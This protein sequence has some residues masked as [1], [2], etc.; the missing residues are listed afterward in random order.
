MIAKIISALITLS[1]L[2]FLITSTY[3]NNVSSDFKKPF[4]EKTKIGLFELN[5]IEND[6]SILFSLDEI[7][8]S[9]T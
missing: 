3:I 7:S 2:V 6:D 9:N 8:K 5:K 4:Y 1:I